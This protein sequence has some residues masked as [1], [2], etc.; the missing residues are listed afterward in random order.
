MHDMQ[1][2]LDLNLLVALDALLE[3]N[4]VSGA[5]GRLHLSEPAMSRTLARIRRALGDPVLVRSGRSMVPTPRAVAMRVDVHELVE[6]ARTL[7]SA[8]PD[9]DLTT[10]T[11]VFTVQADDAIIAVSGAP[12]LAR[13]AT[14][15]PGVTVRFL[16]EGPGD[17][18]LLRQG[19]ADLEIGVIVD[20]APE[21]RVEPLLTDRFVGLVRRG[22]PL[23][24]GRL[25]AERFAAADHLSVSRRGRLSGPIDTLLAE[26]GL[27]RRVAASAPTFCAAQFLLQTTDLVGLSAERMHGP[28]G[29]QAGLVTFEIPLELEPL[30]IAL[31]W[32]SRYD[33]DSAHGWLRRLVHE[34]VGATG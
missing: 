2:K 18:H 30:R 31:A 17:S 1:S 33:A 5:A 19:T 8:D 4:S 20:P 28:I 7:F 10:L 22:H 34:A 24:R 14:E 27:A 15:A 32:H 3:E 6:R 12:L 23:T 11:R 25:T 26:R 9:V 13:I 16:G 21:T 29:E